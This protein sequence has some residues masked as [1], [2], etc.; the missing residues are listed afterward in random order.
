MTDTLQLR[1][2]K[3]WL[4]I[5]VAALE[6]HIAQLVKPCD[7]IDLAKCRALRKNIA[8]S[9][10]HL[11]FIHRCERDLALTSVVWTQNT[12][13]FLIVGC[14]V[15]EALFHYLLLARGKAATTEWRSVVKAPPQSI[16]LNGKRFRSETE[17]FEPA[18]RPIHLPMTFDAMCKRVEK[19]DLTGLKS[20]EFYK[21]LPYLRNLRNRIHIHDVDGLHDTDWVAFTA[22]DLA[23]VKQV[24]AAFFKSSL[25]KDNRPEYFYYL[26]PDA[27]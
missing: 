1:G 14:S 23:L 26:T 22:K 25:F 24:L 6:D 21:H 15:L 7:A 10:Q 19:K 2:G 8:Y 20:D 4:P 11:E 17:Y 5:P 27:G 16:E 18:D 12:K 3:K 9:L 13:T